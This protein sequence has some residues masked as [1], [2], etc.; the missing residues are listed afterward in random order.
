MNN[1]LAILLITLS[2]I[3]A[4]ELD[5]YR[6]VGI[7]QDQFWSGSKIASFQL[8]T[9]HWSELSQ[10][11]V[12][13]IKF[14]EINANSISELLTNKPNGV[15]II[16]DQQSQDNEAQI[17]DL[18]TNNLGPKGATISIYFTYESENI[19][20]HYKEI[21]SQ[22][23]QE[24][25]LQVTSVDQK[26]VLTL[27]D[28][29]NL[30]ES[31]SNFKQNNPSTLIVLGIDENVPSAEIT[32]PID[33]FGIQSSIFFKIAREFK[34]Q[35]RLN[36][37]I[38]FYIS[39]SSSL[40][41][42]GLKQF[43]KK[44]EYQRILSTIDT[45]IIF[46]QIRQNE[47][48]HIEV[49]PQLLN[50]VQALLTESDATFEEAETTNIQNKEIDTIRIYTQKQLQ[51]LTK[52]N[53]TKVQDNQLQIL[54]LVS[55]L[56]DDKP[57]EQQHQDQ[58]FDEAL[59]Q[60]INTP[61]RHPANLQKDSKF[62]NDFNSLLRQLFKHTTKMQY[63]VKDRKFFTSSQLK[64][65]IIKFYSAFID[66]YLILGV[67]AWLVVIYAITKYVPLFSVEQNA[68]KKRK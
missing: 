2:V 22:T 24:Y 11:K 7:E 56:I 34:Y 60:F 30:L 51:I 3:N 31:I 46:D 53:S 50:Q 67:G 13:L 33:R 68:N 58:L 21:Q 55:Q 16:L 19:N 42:Y 36:R 43:Y 10:R 17:W 45:I 1:L 37:N 27:E 12:A 20:N 28:S 44:Q 54:N 39:T 18:I 61:N 62:I 23:E 64:A 63:V 48:L 49:S 41:E 5:V 40:G 6:M 59:S 25:Q 52:Q 66:L 9:T 35:Q 14:S 26:Q 32:I 47:K 4:F 38:I 29:Y 65:Q 57:Y 15:L 8:L